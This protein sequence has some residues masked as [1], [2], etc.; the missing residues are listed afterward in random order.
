[1]TEAAVM[2]KNH[3]PPTEWGSVSCPLAASEA[4]RLGA[5]MESMVMRI[6]TTLADQCPSPK[7]GAA[8]SRFS[9]RVRLTVRS[10]QEG[11]KYCLNCELDRF[12]RSGGVVLETDRAAKEAAGTRLL[13]QRNLDNYWAQIQSLEKEV[14]SV[15]SQDWSEHFRTGGSQDI[16]S[17]CHRTQAY[18]A[19]L[20]SRLAQLYPVGGV[21]RAFED[22]AAAIRQE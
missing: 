14:A 10:F 20:Y 3:R 7:G 15:S 1:M 11:F 6:Y 17:T 13:I 9:N 18:R 19:E 21:R 16:I 5:T 2:M 4:Y 8:L 12:Y 22:M